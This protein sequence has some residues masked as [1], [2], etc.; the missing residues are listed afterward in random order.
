MGIGK[1]WKEILDVTDKI[2][3]TNHVITLFYRSYHLFVH[4]LA[5]MWLNKSLS[6]HRM[7]QEE[8]GSLS[9]ETS[10]RLEE[11]A[12]WLFLALFGRF[13][14]IAETFRDTHFEV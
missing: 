5:L 9:E 1:K 2:T 11:D 12:I 14:Q 13:T 3:F 10:V 6:I 4:V 8:A 7:I